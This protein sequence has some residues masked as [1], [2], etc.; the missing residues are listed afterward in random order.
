MSRKLSRFVLFSTAI[1]C[2]FPTKVKILIWRIK[3]EEKSSFGAKTWN[4]VSPCANLDWFRSFDYFSFL[5]C[6]FFAFSFGFNFVLPPYCTQHFPPI[7]IFHSPKQQHL[8]V[9]FTQHNT[10]KKNEKCEF[11]NEIMLGGWEMVGWGEK[12]IYSSSFS[13]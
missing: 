5:Q 8:V 6:K 1:R 3:D 4:W 11:Y 12:H 13:M 9:F 10:K 2:A 7:L